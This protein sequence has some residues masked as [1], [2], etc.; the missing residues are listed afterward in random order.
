MQAQ[1]LLYDQIYDLVA[2]RVVVDSVRECYEALGVVHAELEADARALQGLHRAA[3]GEHVPVAAHHRD[4]PVRRAHGG[5]DPHPR[6]AP[7]RRGRASP[8]TGATR[9]ASASPTQDAQRFTWLRQLLEWQQNVQDPQEFL[10]LGEGRPVQRRGLRLHAARATCST[11]PKARR[12]STSPTAFTPR[13]A[14]TAPAR[15]S[16]AA[17]CRCAIACAAATRVEIITTASQTPSK[18]WLN[19]VKTSRAKAKIRNWI[20]F[21]QRTRSVAV[22]REILERDLS[23]Y[24]LDL[25]KL[26]KDG[27][28]AQVVSGAVATRRGDPARQHR[29]RQAHLAPGARPPAAARSAAAAAGRKKARCKRL[30]RKIAR[31]SNGGVRVSGVED[32]LVRFGKCCDPLPGERILGFITRG[33][34]VTVHAVDCPRVLESDPQRRVEVVWENGAAAPRPVTVE[35]MCIDE[36]GLLAGDQQGDQRR[37]RQHQPRPGA[38]RPRQEG[39]QHASRWWSAAPTSSTASSARSA[40]C[41]AS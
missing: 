29:L 41:A 18:D 10:R 24:H 25:G 2:F 23:R 5:A 35:V 1:N 12:S 31:Q 3:Q 13:S 14:T 17:W 4:R 37:R 19:F 36:P 20:K 8:R 34:G 26:R 15:A 39:R 11:S 6:D 9:A 33:R 27:R 22:G 30:F 32:M 16:T 21:Q 7:R 38:Q 40:R 28:L